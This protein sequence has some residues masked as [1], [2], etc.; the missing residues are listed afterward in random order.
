VPSPCYC[1]TRHTSYD[2]GGIHCPG[3]GQLLVA[4]TPHR[5]WWRLRRAA[6]RARLIHPVLWVLA[7][8]M[9][10]VTAAIIYV[11]ATGAGQ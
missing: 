4:E 10:A 8:A 2:P 3:C 11:M 1:A 9:A 6:W 5:R 7:A